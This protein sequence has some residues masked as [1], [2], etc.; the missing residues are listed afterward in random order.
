[1]LKII[2]IIDVLC[3]PLSDCLSPLFLSFYVSLYLCMYVDTH[4]HFWSVF[5]LEKIKLI[6]NVLSVLAF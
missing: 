5:S 2:E 1:M 3:L 4:P 6:L